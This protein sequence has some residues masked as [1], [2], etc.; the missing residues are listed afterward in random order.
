M[1]GTHAAV[2]FGRRGRS[3]ALAGILAGALLAI[4]A[5]ASAAG[6]ASPTVATP[7]HS[8][9]VCAPVPLDQ[10]RCH[11]LVV[12]GTDGTPLATASYQNGYVPADLRGAYKLGAEPT[13]TW[14]AN[15][16]TVAIVDAYD[17]PNA[18]ADL[19]AYR[20][21]F[22]L[23]VCADGTVTSCGL[24]TKVEPTGTRG[25]TGWGEE[26]DLDID[27]VSAVCP[28]CAIVLDEGKSNSLTDLG[29]AVDDAARRSSVAAISNSYGTSGEFS[30]ETSYNSYYDH[31]HIAVTASAGDSGYG[32]EFP[33]ASNTV[34]AVGGTSLYK[35]SSTVTSAKRT[36]TDGNTWAETVWSGTGSGCSAYFTRQTWQTT[37][38][39]ST[40]TCTMR[41][42][43]DVAAEADPNTG[44]AV[45]DSYGSTKN[46]DWYEFGGTSVAS[47]IIAS[48]FALNGNTGSSSSDTY[49]AAYLY[50][51]TASL[52][53]VTAGS[54][55]NCTRGSKRSTNTGNGY[56]CTAQTGY[57]GPTGLGTPNS[58]G[59]F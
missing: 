5:A 49:P 19:A 16:K 37:A 7:A 29:S 57:D 51:G 41:V 8:T 45:Y 23:P 4:P 43:G 36:G 59:A 27:M 17:N 42:I 32:A 55:G 2:A 38:V 58:T 48:V 30:G 53:D 26:I 14:T 24:F 13:G 25:D 20:A 33:A 52:F 40:G 9:P 56:L 50:A 15:G 34:V 11:A 1:R 54:N 28:S 31:P 18:A 10:A 6:S 44:V 22:G 46:N 12:T 35:N 47:P 21:Q 3:S 39:P